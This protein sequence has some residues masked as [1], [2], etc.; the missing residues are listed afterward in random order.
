MTRAWHLRQ[1]G[2]AF[3]VKVHIYCMNDEDLSSEAEA[4][5]FI[6]ST[7]SK[8]QE[9]AEY[10]LDAWMALLIE[11]EVRYD[12][13]KEGISRAIEKALKSLPYHFQYPLN[14][15][16]LIS[17]HEKLNNYYDIDT[18][19]D[20]IDKVREEIDDIQ[21][22]IKRSFNQQF[23]RVRYGGQ[24][25]SVAGNSEIWFRVSSVGYNWVDTIYVFTSSIRRAYQISHIS[26][27]RDSESDNTEVEYFY[28]AKDGTLYKHL[29]IDE[30]LEEEHEHSPVFDS[31][32]INRG[33][34]S[35]LR[36]LLESGTGYY[37]SITFLEIEG[38][39]PQRDHWNY[40]IKK[41]RDKSCIKSIKENYRR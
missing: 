12:V 21:E 3:P 8:D 26:I 6:I 1:D 24:Y 14:T 5:A 29:P 32:N 27:C 23:C 20:F 17:I 2:E 16:S 11:D 34:L 15:S 4:S 28:K 35:T 37:D 36:G 18:L 33:F 40:L 25:N 38:I 30:Y 41:E 22:T 39:L 7:K 31:V 9:Y 13:D 10:V 19:Y